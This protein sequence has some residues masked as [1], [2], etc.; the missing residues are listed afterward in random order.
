MHTP[1][2]FERLFQAS[3][4]CYLVLSPDLTIVAVSDAYL[5]ATMTHRD[6][7]VGRALFEVF[8]DNPDDPQADG[9]AK[10]R[11]SLLRVLEHQRPDRMSIQKYDIRRPA[12]EGGE[13]EV[14]YWSPLNTPVLNDQGVVIYIIHCV[15]DVTELVRLQQR[16]NEQGE[17]YRQLLVRSEQHYAQLLNAAP[18]AI[19]VVAADGTIDFVNQQAEQMFG[20]TRSELLHAK[21]GLLIPKRLQEVHTQHT[22]RYLAD[23]QLRA[24]GHNQ[25]LF[26]QHKDGTEFP[27]EVSLSPLRIEGQWTVTAAVRDV[28]ARKQIESLMKLNADRFESA[29]ESMQDAFAMYDVS[30]LLVRCNLA[31]REL[32]GVPLETQLIGAAHVQI[33]DTWLVTHLDADNRESLRQRWLAGARD[34]PQTFDLRTS[35]GKTLRV[36]IRRTTEGGLVE[37]IW[38]LTDDERRADE[39][40]SA[41]VAAEAASAAKTEFLSSVSHELRTPMNAILGFAQLLH[42]DVRDPLPLRHRERVQQILSSGQHLLRLIEDVL[43]LSG[44]EAGRVSIAPEAIYVENLVSEVVFALE[45]FATR[46][47]VLLNIESVASDF[48]VFSADRLRL[49]Q[50]LMNFGSNAIKYNRAN[51]TVTFRATYDAEWVRIAVLDNGIGIPPE[52]QAKLFQAFQRAGQEVGPIPGTGIGLLVAKRLAELMHGSVGFRSEPGVGSE[53]WVELPRAIRAERMI[54]AAHGGG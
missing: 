26:G 5:R 21:L 18:D 2:D 33:V 14:R 27:I 17:A 50:I 47:A 23:P 13:F 22:S 10:L 48:P 3:P 40:R 39:L 8:P 34:Q 11:E 28:S 45:P 31:Y 41:R 37:V 36:S 16:E 15:D 51:G 12:A 42:R 32:L 35:S 54:P 1:P 43:D 52:Q 38:D 46:Q 29:V 9:V 44:I 19:V 49:T 24:M 7:I 25:E 4:G 53:F 6:V 30:D 20:Y